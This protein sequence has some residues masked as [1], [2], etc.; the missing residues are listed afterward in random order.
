VQTFID[1]VQRQSEKR[2]A[3]LAL[4]KTQLRERQRSE[5]ARAAKGQQS[6]QNDEAKTRAGRFRRGLRGVWDWL[7]GKSK[8]TKRQ[9]EREAKLAVQRDR[10][11]REAMI[12]KQL[13]Q[14]CSIQGE[15]IEARRARDEQISDLRRDVPEMMKGRS[16]PH[17]EQQHYKDGRTQTDLSNAPKRSTGRRIER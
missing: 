10:D 5:R 15:I 6:R 16:A 1:E 7:I 13:S 9:N 14:R 17:V 8:E 11:E 2:T 12:K 4:K 3:T